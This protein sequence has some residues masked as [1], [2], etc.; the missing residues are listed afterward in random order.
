MATFNLGSI[1]LTG[2]LHTDMT[3]EGFDPTALVDMLRDIAE[4]VEDGALSGDVID[5]NGVTVTLWA[6]A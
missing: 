4:A 2:E 3:G 6:I 5:P 1:A